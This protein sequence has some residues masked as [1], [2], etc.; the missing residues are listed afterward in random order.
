[1]N[2]TLS[3][4]GVSPV[5]REVI[6]HS[7]GG[8]AAQM[9]RRV[10]EHTGSEVP[11]DLD[12]YAARYVQRYLGVL[13]ES[14][15]C[16]PGAHAALMELRQRGYRLALTTNKPGVPTAALVDYLG[17][18]H[19]FD[20]VIAGD[21]LSVKKPDPRHLTEAVDR[22]G[23]GP[24]VMVGDSAPDAG[25]AKNASYPFVAVSFGYHS[26]PLSALEAVAVIDH[27][28]E[29]PDVVSSLIPA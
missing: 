15:T 22:C 17:L 21:T 8:G 20:V 5:D 11:D 25:A 28:A 26:K 14:T 7:I 2:Q 29:L 10:L 16:F 18:G 3:A 9:L 19:Y 27:L 24:A 4:L 1:M 6:R 12:A 13:T 23:G